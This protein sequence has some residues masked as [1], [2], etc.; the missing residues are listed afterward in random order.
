MRVAMSSYAFNNEGGI[1]RASYEL[2]LRM[3]DRIDLT[4]VSAHIDPLPP[5]PLTWHRVPMKPAPRFA[6]PM[7]YSA[8]ASRSIRGLDFDVIHNQ[9]GC[10]TRMQDVITAHSCHRA[11]WEMKLRNG[12]A[13]RAV[14][15]PFHHAV[16]RVEQSNYRPDRFRRAIAVSPSVGRELTQ[17][18]GVDPD[19]ITVIPNAVDV[20][21]FQ[22]ADAADRRARVRAGHGY[23]DDDVVLLFVGKE[24]R[25]KGLAAIIDALPSL[26]AAAKLLVVGGADP[27]AFRAQARSAGVGDRVTFAGHSPTVEDYFQA[28]DVFVFPTMYEAFGLVMLEAAAAGL[29]VVA[30]PLGVAE[31]FIEVGRNGAYVERDGASVARAVAPLVADRDLRRRLG[32]NARADA[33]RYTSWDT[34]AARTLEVYEDVAEAKRRDGV[35]R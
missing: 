3:A 31:E 11:W 28:G 35:L 23:T 20:T 7:T 21:R 34:V 15:N 14:A 13:L 33:E 12:E 6:I 32:E 25:R 1:E 17:Y 5:A 29:P 24:F 9:G 19:R 10:A 30:T 2:A 26:P 27:A 8:A 16:L 18:Y 4:L 22:P